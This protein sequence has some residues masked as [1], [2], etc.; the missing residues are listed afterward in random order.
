MIGKPAGDQT[1][2]CSRQAGFKGR[3]PLFLVSKQN[4][5][6]SQCVWCI[7]NHR[8]W[9]WIEKIMAPQNREGQ[10]LKK[11]KPSNCTKVDFRTPKKF[12]VRCY[13]III[14]QMWFVKF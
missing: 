1:F 12:F 9:N 13:V 10:K 8:K 5:N 3:A 4:F 14:V 11:N 6:S 2:K 7:K